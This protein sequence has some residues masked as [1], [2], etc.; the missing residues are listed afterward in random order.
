MLM[1]IAELWLTQKGKLDRA[2]RAYEKVLSF[3]ATN[4]A[5]RRAAGPDL[6]ERQ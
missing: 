2:A 5:G 3:D 1:K 4:L 6:P